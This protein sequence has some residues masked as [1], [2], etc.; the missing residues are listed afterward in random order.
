MK[1]YRGLTY[2]L[3]ALLLSFLTPTFAAD[4]DS[5]EIPEVRKIESNPEPIQDGDNPAFAANTDS[6]EI[7]EV[8]KIEGNPGKVWDDISW[9]DMN[10]TEQQLWE[11]LGWNAH[12]WENDTAKKP[13]SENK[14][15]KELTE[16]E[17]QAAEK[18]RYTEQTWDN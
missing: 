18:L 14:N 9:A 11:V 4:T 6:L 7:P 15:W 8:R 10:S 3:S 2:L 17:Q 13:A 5:S 1:L 12:D 16:E